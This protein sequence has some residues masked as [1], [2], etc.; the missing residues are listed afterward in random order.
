VEPA[1]CTV[2]VGA[3]EPVRAAHVV[4]AAIGVPFVALLGLEIT[5][6]LRG[7]TPLPAWLGAWAGIAAVTLCAPAACVCFAPGRYSPSIRWFGA[8]ALTLTVYMVDAST[9]YASHHRVIVFS[10]LAFWSIPIVMA[11]WFRACLA[12]AR[13]LFETNVPVEP[14]GWI[15]RVVRPRVRSFNDLELALVWAPAGAFA[16]LGSFNLLTATGPYDATVGWQ[17]EAHDAYW[18]MAG[19]ALITLGSTVAVLWTARGSAGPVGTAAD[20]RAEWAIWAS[21]VYALLALILFL[22]T[23]TELIPET[24]ADLV[25]AAYTL[26]YA[27]LLIET[28]AYETVERTYRRTRQRALG[29]LLGVAGALI[30]AAAIPGDSLDKAAI[31]GVLACVFPIAPRLVDL[32]HGVPLAQIEPPVVVIPDEISSASGLSPTTLFRL[33]AVLARGE[34]AA[35]PSSLAAAFIA[36]EAISNDRLAFLVSLGN[37]QTRRKDQRID[38]ELELFVQRFPLFARPGAPDTRRSPEECGRTLARLVLDTME[39]QPPPGRPAR[40][41]ANPPFSSLFTHLCLVVLDRPA[42][43]EDFPEMQRV[44]VWGADASTSYWQLWELSDEALDA[45]SR[46]GRE[47][48]RKK[49]TKP[50]D[51]GRRRVYDGAVADRHNDVFDA[52]RRRLKTAIAARSS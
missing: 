13:E 29:V 18:V 23:A 46:A 51:S 35:D 32:I 36:L 47:R 25:V 1:G 42:R 16:I 43:D 5:A 7:H 44:T 48:G 22:G 8:A 34:G 20:V 27:L 9:G 31:A 33:E 4:A 39:S 28:S 26:I 21:V 11:I 19:W 41:E 12:M 50:S 38:D 15:A 49:W 40:R 24:D 2:R 10:H 52:W 45:R 6:A 14:G 30:I 17:Y 3:P 37:G